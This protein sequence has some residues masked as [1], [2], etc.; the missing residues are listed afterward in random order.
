[1]DDEIDDLEKDFLEKERKLEELEKE[2]AD[3]KKAL[4]VLRDMKKRDL[5]GKLAELLKEI[6]LLSMNSTKI[7]NT[8]RVRTL[9]NTPRG[10]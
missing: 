2:V 10:I 8:L 3:A 7:T 5:E 9:N 4:S 1:M 6:E